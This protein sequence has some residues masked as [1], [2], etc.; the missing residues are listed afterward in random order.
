MEEKRRHRRIV[1][2]GIHG[3]LLFTSK[4]EII[5]I[6]IGGA[7][8]RVNRSLT[9]GK[10][11][12]IKLE[13]KEKN[14]ELKSIVIWSVLRGSQKGHHGDVVPVYH[15]GVKFSNIFNGKSAALIDFIE[16]HRI[17][18]SEDR[19]KGLRFKIH[20]EKDTVLYCDS[21]YKVKL[22]SLSGMLI[23]TEQPFNPDEKFQME[24]FLAGGKEAK[25]TGKIVTCIE[26]AGGA[27]RGFDIGVEFLE[28]HEKDRANLESFIRSI[29]GAGKN[30]AA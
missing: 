8:I 28:M 9:I 26:A 21:G 22:I 5:N 23:E 16:E 18:E 25:L 7:A 29:S 14:V 4:I 11:Y 15:A 20:P 12:L 6:S 24:I 10:E 17:V 2:Q 3:N 27:H 30:S 13:N 19:L 1:V